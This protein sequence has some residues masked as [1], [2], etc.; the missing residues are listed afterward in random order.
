MEVVIIHINNAGWTLREMSFLI[1]QICSDHSVKC[2][3]Y[4][5]QAQFEFFNCQTFTTDGFP[6]LRGVGL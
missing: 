4:I 5:H 2:M 3:G 1:S 6:S